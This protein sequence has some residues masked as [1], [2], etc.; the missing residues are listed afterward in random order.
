ME[1][2]KSIS[3]LKRF[4]GL[5]H[6][7][8]ACITF[9][10][11]GLMYL[12]SNYGRGL[13]WLTSESF[14]QSPDFTRKVQNDITNIFD[15]IRYQEIFE[16]NGTLDYSK[17]VL[18]V[19]SGPGDDRSYTLNDI[20]VYGKSLGYYL[21][22]ADDFALKGSPDSIPEEEQEQ[23]YVIYRCYQDRKSVV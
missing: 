3:M 17:V 10:G 4:V 16:T 13:S 21:D 15:Y 8:F 12:N 22:E 23:V 11:I 7:I 9:T 18:E 2:M 5:F 14:E 20:I 19:S 6:V 1:H